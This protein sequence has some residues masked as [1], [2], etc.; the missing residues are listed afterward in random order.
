LALF[1]VW[2]TESLRPAVHAFEAGDRSR[3]DVLELRRGV[4]NRALEVAPVNAS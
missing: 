4:R 2:S 1:I 3:G